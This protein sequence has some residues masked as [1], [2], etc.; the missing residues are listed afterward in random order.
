[1]D[2][3][4]GLTTKAVQ[5]SSMF[6][7]GFGIYTK[8]CPKQLNVWTGIL[9]LQPKLSKAAQCLDRD[10]GFTL[11]AVQSSSMFGQ[12]FWIYSQSCPKQLNVWTGIR[13]LQ[14]KLSKAAQCLDKVSGL[15]A[16]AV[17][18]SSKFGQEFWIYIQSCPKQLNVWT[19]MQD[20]LPK[21]SEAAPALDWI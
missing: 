19:G 14:P 17:Q 6:G 2:R 8:S 21:L 1:M 5:S 7:Q 4:S 12:E 16:K 15:T 11:K 9:D 18:S 13:D 20:L 10:S 3:D